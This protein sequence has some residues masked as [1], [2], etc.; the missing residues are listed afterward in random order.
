MQ[1][2]LTLI[3]LSFL[4]IHV[5]IQ[6]QEHVHFGLNAYNEQ[7]DNQCAHTSI[8]EHR[9]AHDPAYAQE[10]LQRETSLTA[11]I[12]QYE[13]GYL[14][15]NDEILTIPVVVHIIHK[16]ES[17]GDDT[18]IS[19]EQV[20]SAINGL[21]E[22]FR[23]VSGTWGDGDGVD[24]GVEFC[25][26]QRDPSGNAHS[27]INRVN[28][29]SVSLYCDQGITAGQ[30]QGASETAVKQL[31]QWPNQQYYN[32]WVVSEIEN[33]NGGSGIQGYA[34]FP[35]TS[36]VDGTVILFNAFGTVGTLK[37]YT[38]RN[39]TLTHELGHAF[40]LFHTFQGGS[41]SETDCTLQGDR[42]CDTPP[43]VLN[44]NCS[45]AACS[46][47]QQVENYLDYTSQTC[48]N[49]FT[50]GQK[51]RMRMSIQNSRPNLLESDGCEP[52]ATALADAAISAIL[53]P[54]G[55]ACS[56]M[57]EPR[58]TLQNAG[59]TT[60]STVSIEY[61]TSGPWQAHPWSGLL[62]PGQSTQVVLPTYN[63]GWGTR[64][65]Q[66][67]TANPN[68]ASDVNDANNEMSKV[69]QAVQNGHN[70][71][72]TLTLDNL[73]SQ[74][75]WLLRDANGNVMISGGPY[76][77]FQNGTIHT[78]PICLENGC[79]EFE[80]NDSGNN[81]MC[82]FSGQGGFLLSDSEGNEIAA[83]TEFGSQQIDEF[84]LEDD[85]TPPPPVAPIADFSASATQ[86][87]AGESIT[88]INAS[89]GEVVIY[90]WQFPGGNPSSS[91]AA[92]P[93]PIT[94]NTPGTY[95]A[96]LT[97]SNAGGSDVET[98]SNYI[99]VLANQTWY[100]DSDGDGYGDENNTTISCTQ[101]AGYVSNA[102]DCDDSDPQ[103]WNSC[104]DCA[105][106]MN[107]DAQWDDCGVC[108]N[109]PDN[110]CN[111]CEEL[112]IALI[113]A[114]DPTCYQAANGS[115]EIA[116]DS[117]SGDYSI[118]WSDGSNALI[119][120][121]LAA[122]TYQ[123]VASS[124]GCQSELDITLLQ[125]DPI[126]IDIGNIGHVGCGEEGTGTLTINV[127]GGTGALT[128][129]AMG[130]TIS[131][132]TYTGLD[133]GTYSI[134]VSDA[135]GCEISTEV[136]IYQVPCDGLESTSLIAAQC[137]ESSLPFF[138]HVSCEPVPAALAYE[139]RFTPADGQAGLQSFTVTTPGPNLLPAEVEQIIPLAVYQIDVKGN[140]P[141]ASSDWGASCTVAF[142]IGMS[143]LVAEDCDNTSLPENASIA[144]QQIS[145]AELYEFR[146]EHMESGV[147]TYAYAD[148]GEEVFISE[149]EDLQTGTLYL[150]DVR[151]RYRNVWGGHGES[152]IIG[153]EKN[154]N[155][156]VFESWVCN[157]FAIDMK[158]DSTWLQ[159]INGASV[160]AIEFSGTALTTPV[161]V[162]STNRT[163]GPGLL[164]FLPEGDTLQARARIQIDGGWTPWSDY[165]E[166]AF[167]NPEAGE[168]ETEN[169]TQ[170]HTLNMF[171]YPNPL[172][173]GNALQ[174]RMNGDWE[175]V[176]LTLRNLAGVAL[177]T[178]RKNFTHM[179]AQTLELP[180]IES[181]IYFVTAVHGTSTLTKKLIV[182]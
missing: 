91:T 124:E 126:S 176:E 40:A 128:I 49:M 156:P 88:Y 119:R 19:D 101:P 64:T 165:C 169:E 181:G 29:C 106:V 172:L 116:V 52:V 3:F 21:N 134:V 2:K 144:C 98:K 142:T 28:G 114:I 33:N 93:G 81:G 16:G 180:D 38:N 97:V 133:E 45:S 160:Y 89:S 27:G 58:V 67:R 105:G 113:E 63:G 166:V 25:L 71:T 20:Y 1:G 102:D 46:G 178:F 157:N 158:K 118:E 17:Y 137:D 85:S 143:S 146:F 8:H 42:V 170:K 55:S 168:G 162:Q 140:H 56:N 43:T 96:Q 139:W 84:C 60:L 115:I 161:E 150:T 164:A 15:K 5:H 127:S 153:I 182:Q 147:R 155:I 87:C 18:N 34:Y 83:G 10:Q 177:G 26:A 154:I 117:Y 66:V 37:S 125:P 179:E 149:I 62:G 76:S 131:P 41:C 32:I 136:T 53:K 112:S 94:Y 148:Q 9:M 90:Q 141:E 99:T 129:L 121:N 151:V 152:C 103:D 79:Y 123:V 73:G 24:V 59:S 175:N 50:E 109:N 104:Y 135:N 159:P 163:F 4:L 23:K 171:L 145:G 65:L 82:C 174:A 12:Q 74:N 173:S 30:G 132:G 31:S 7:A 107:G 77:N 122:G 100:A 72:L 57:I 130:Q 138:T 54:E 68:G 14:P 110:D 86:L 51:T 95:H 75:T 6:A 70:L 36:I 48:K 78:V 44:S 61:R 108:D 120:D 35:T 47:T 39:R 13:A 92:N 111:P 22:D 69:Y 11:L 80:I 167:I